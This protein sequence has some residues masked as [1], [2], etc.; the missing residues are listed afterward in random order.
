MWPIFEAAEEEIINQDGDS[1][2]DEV[3]AV[4]EQEL[5]RPPTAEEIEKAFEKQVKILVDGQ[6]VEFEENNLPGLLE[7]AIAQLLRFDLAPEEF[8]AQQAAG[9]LLIDGKEI[10]IR[11]NADGTETPY[12]R[13]RPDFDPRDNLLAL[14]RY[15]PPYEPPA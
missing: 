10:I 8:V 3:T 14:P 1:I 9:I 7:E 2:R 11:H 4:L 6:Q 12:Y 13:D 5:G 15:I